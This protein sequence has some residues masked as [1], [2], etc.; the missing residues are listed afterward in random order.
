MTRE[1]H[2][3]KGGQQ[4][5]PIS[6]DELKALAES[7]QLQPGDLVWKEGM[8]GWLPASKVKGLFAL[9]VQRIGPPPMPSGATPTPPPMPG[10]LQPLSLGVDR[11]RFPLYGYR[12]ALIVVALAT[13]LPWI[14][15]TSSLDYDSNRI[16]GM[17]GYGSF[18]VNTPDPVRTAGKAS[19]GIHGVGTLWGVMALLVGVAGIA[20]S[21]IGPSR[22]LKANSRLGMAG[23]GGAVVLLA[24]IVMATSSSLAPTESNYRDAFGNSASSSISY[25]FGIYLTI[26]AGLGAAATGYLHSWNVA[27]AE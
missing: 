22:Y 13:L 26:V 3:S 11:Q 17:S 21:F 7:G 1:W 16:P 8:D 12:A 19:V 24:F 15:I 5:G 10:K 14:S 18:G 9:D 20:L 27:A 4:H 23:V 2:Y 25:A 6:H